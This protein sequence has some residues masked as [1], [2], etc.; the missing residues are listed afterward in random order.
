MAAVLGMLMLIL[1]AN[2]ALKGAREGIALCTAT[3]LPSLFPFFVLSGLLTFALSGTKSKFLRPLGRFCGMPEGSES[4]LLIGLLGGYPT[5]AHTVTQVWQDGKLTER[6]AKHLLSF[7]SNAGPAFLFGIC[8]SL[9]TNWWMPLLLWGIQIVSALLTA[10]YLRAPH[11]NH[12]G[13][14]AGS[15]FS[16]PLALDRA[17]RTS[18]RVC[19]WVVLFRIG[20][21]CLEQRILYF[22][23]LLPRLLISGILELTNGCCLLT[24]A[25][26]E[27]L[28]FLLAGVF[29]SFGGLCVLMQTAS[30]TGRLGIGSYLKGKLVQTLLCLLLSLPIVFRTEFPAIPAMIPAV[31]LFLIFK[32][33]K[34]SCGKMRTV[35]V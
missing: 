30:V 12:A 17:I 34:K 24:S 13:I 35:G 7:C 14:T 29:L 16:L 19:G 25:P 5:G 22:L 23:P 15:G 33:G 32:K 8:G 9:F 6:D 1:D 31:I 11:R 18:A 28:R 27:E 10:H 26:S 2:T 20:I 4:L 3:V 21:T